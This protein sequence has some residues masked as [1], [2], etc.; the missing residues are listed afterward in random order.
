MKT[1]IVPAWEFYDEETRQFINGKETKIVMEHSL[2][3]IS[4]WEAVYNKPFLSTDLTGMEML[5]Y[6][7]CMT[8]SPNIS[9]YAY[10]ALTEENIKDIEDYVS[11][12]MSAKRI[13]ALDAKTKG[14]NKKK[15]RK[16]DIPVEAVYYWMTQLGIPFEPCEKWHLNRLLSLI[17]YCSEKNEEANPNTKKKKKSSKQLMSEYAKINEQNAK[18]LF[19]KEG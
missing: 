5:E 15:K 17:E 18:I 6:I 19:S 9:D 10:L 2:V 13:Q 8:V 4:K 11:A 12:P 1:I 7:K 3:S 14:K 16:N